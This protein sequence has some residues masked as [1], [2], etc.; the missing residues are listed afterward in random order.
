MK[1]D[2]ALKYVLNKI[3]QKNTEKG[4]TSEKMVKI[5]ADKSND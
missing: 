2:V 4:I 1:D 3:F 5:K